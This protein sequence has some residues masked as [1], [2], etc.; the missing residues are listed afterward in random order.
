MQTIECMFNV[1]S[2]GNTCNRNIITTKKSLWV[3]DK[4]S[5]INQFLNIS[6]FAT[7]KKLNYIFVYDDNFLKLFR[8]T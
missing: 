1:E 5:H 7:G 2:D 8:D 6:L 4:N 3:P